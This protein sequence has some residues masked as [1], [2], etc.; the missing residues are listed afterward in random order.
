MSR[1]FANRRRI[2]LEGGE[3]ERSSLAENAIEGGHGRGRF[4]VPLVAHDSQADASSSYM[5]TTTESMVLSQAPS[6][7]TVA[8]NISGPSRSGLLGDVALSNEQMEAVLTGSTTEPLHEQAQA[9][10]G[11]EWGGFFLLLAIILMSGPQ[12][13][14]EMH[15]LCGIDPREEIINFVGWILAPV[16]LSRAV[17]FVAYR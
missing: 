13:G 5:N 3:A 9:T 11:Y 7:Y 10:L 4:S 6:E 1:S 12:A 17:I 16:A 15:D 2:D 8:S 14:L